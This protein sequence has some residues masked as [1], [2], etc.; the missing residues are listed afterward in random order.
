[1]ECIPLR[2]NRRSQAFSRRRRVGME[3][4]AAI[5]QSRRKDIIHSVG[6]GGGRSQRVGAGFKATLKT[7]LLCLDKHST[8]FFG[9]SDGGS[10]IHWLWDSRGMARFDC[11]VMCRRDKVSPSLK[12]AG[13]TQACM[14]PIFGKSAT[15][16]RRVFKPRHITPIDDSF[17]ERG[18]TDEFVCSFL[19]EII[20][21]GFPADI[22]MDEETSESEPLQRLKER[23]QSSLI[24]KVAPGKMKH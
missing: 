8:H 11:I 23:H 3:S 17:L 16:L 4:V 15:S 5:A 6:A 1:M 21:G 22:T 10:I 7:V 2:N 13:I 14:G 24:L 12:P 9:Q 20:K 19:T 18:Q